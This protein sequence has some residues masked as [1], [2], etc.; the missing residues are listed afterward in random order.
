MNEAELLPIKVVVPRPDDYKAPPPARGST[1]V[2]G[3]V[4]TALRQK[5]ANEVRAVETHFDRSFKTSKG[6]P[7][8]AKVVLKPEAVA[9][10]HRPSDLF[11]ND[12]CPI[13]GG[14]RLGELYVSVEPQGLDR[15][16]KRIESN[17][18][19][20]VIANLST[21]QTIDPYSVT[22]VLGGESLI[23]LQKHLEAK[24][25]PLR[26]RLFRHLS[27]QLN[28]R[29]DTYFEAVA[30]QQGVQDLEILDYA[31]GLKVYRLRNAPPKALNALIKVVGVQSLSLFPAYRVV[32][33]MSRALGKVTA[34]D[35]PAPEQGRD[36]PT[37]GLIDTGTDPNNP[38][39][40]AWVVARHDLVPQDQQDNEH[41]SFV[42]GLLVHGRR[43]NHNDSRFPSASSK[44]VDVVALDRN[45]EITEDE[46]LIVID[47]A[48]KKFP[49]V[50]IWNLS[51]GQSTPCND[52]V[53][54][55]LGAALDER[56]ERHGVLFVIAAG[57]YNQ[58]PLRNWPPQDGIDEDDRICP[59]ADSLRAITVG[60]VAHLDTPST[61]VKRGE[62]SP[63]SRRGPGPAY[64]IKPEL[65]C[66]GG[67]CDSNG[68]CVQ[69][70]IISLD[71]H[72]H[73]AENI[74]TSFAN[75]LVSSLAANVE[76]ELR[77]T[78]DAAPRA[79]VKAMMVHSAFLKNA[80][81]SNEGLDYLGIGCPPDLAQIINCRQSSATVIF[82]I[83]VRTKPDFG[84]RP[85]P[86]PS[87]LLDGSGSQFEIFMTLVYE[88]P[89]DRKFGI[90]YCRCNITA[91]LGTVSF[92]PKTQKETYVRQV[93][94]VPKSLSDGYEQELIKNG[95]KWSPL[96]LYHRKFSRG[97]SE[98]SW[99]LTLDMQTR[100]DVAD[101]V[102]QNVV[103]IATIRSADTTLPIYNEL[104]REME[105]LSW[106]AQDLQIRSRFRMKP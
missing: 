34:L 86:L 18:S 70:G 97:Q 27:T 8:V 52:S 25:D 20:H 24:K 28:D 40:Q 46:L 75:P 16:A 43:L 71:A 6:V 44:I 62:P 79:L 73:K 72:G 98:R 53:F 96:K 92:D 82:Q 69:S 85:F 90:E 13:I 63:F 42:G 17:E 38:L 48:L 45:G 80:P 26:V 15:L 93:P 23:E 1:K 47:A 77:V 95:F 91:S 103:L 10:S 41:G 83:P 3:T 68:E 87:C 7:A 105:R 5:L 22:D 89:L 88:P 2:F 21:L 65:S 60:S 19:K 12:T 104:V 59:P 30:R 37:V 74:G 61:C 78:A 39:L 81:L 51:L 101:D 99:R 55:E 64:L 66:F 9:K 54:S 32:R 31:D 36:Y 49:E 57:N 35:F 102:E 14:N 58:A 94:G 67:N 11:D 4:D 33:T 84:K 100:A 29:L 106:G 50:K 56:S 76:A